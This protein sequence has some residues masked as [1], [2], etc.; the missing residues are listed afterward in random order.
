LAI[1]IAITASVLQYFF[2]NFVE[3]RLYRITGLLSTYSFTVFCL[4]GLVGAA[5]AAGYSSKLTANSSKDGF[6]FS[7]DSL[8]GPANEIIIYFISAGM[9][10]GCGILSGI[11]C[12]CI[13][14][15]KTDDM[16][17]DRVEFKPD[18]C[19]FYSTARV[20]PSLIV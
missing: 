8:H 10:I 12:Y 9:G 4:Q 18:D 7:S 19:I 14:K 11:P 1:V 15:Y 6:T 20:N 13:N 5:F 2:D 16:F 3:K 17:H